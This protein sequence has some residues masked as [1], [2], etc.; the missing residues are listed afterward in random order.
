M[1]IFLF[2]LHMNS[3]SITFRHLDTYLDSCIDM[4]C[5]RCSGNHDCHHKGLIQSFLT[6]TKSSS[7]LLDAYFQ[8][9][10]HGLFH[11]I[12]CGFIISLLHKDKNIGVDNCIL[13]K[14]Y[15]SAFLHDILK[16]NGYSQEEHDARLSEF[17]P[18]LNDETYMHSN[19]HIT[20]QNKYLILADRIELTRYPDYKSWVDE[21]YEIIFQTMEETTKFSI[22][23]FYSKIR[24]VLLFFFSNSD[25]IFLRH[26]LEKI[27][28]GD[29][30]KH[31]IFPPENSYL[32]ISN[33]YPIEIDRQPFGIINNWNTNATNGA[34]S[35]H[36]MECNWN[37]V[38]GYIRYEDFCDFGS[39]IINSHERDHLYAN[40]SIELKNWIFMYQNIDE[41][42]FQIVKLIEND[43]NILPQQLINKL[44]TFVKLIKDR[45]IV[46]NS[47]L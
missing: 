7:H 22:E 3:L 8:D 13:E 2:I 1:K 15:A 4:I 43:I 32:E 29:F 24:N 40:G 16:C 20:L 6:P 38:K 28:A 21:R 14:E 33:G 12:M 47:C 26:G 31:S 30:A 37:K 9:T 39:K 10:E 44:C 23:Q 42:N 27:E 36:G 11:G 5:S 18:N 45:L 41:D 25:S 17:Y 35:N 46:L 34:C 19:P